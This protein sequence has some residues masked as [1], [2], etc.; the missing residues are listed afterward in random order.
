[1]LRLGTTGLMLLW[2]LKKSPPEGFNNERVAP[3]LLCGM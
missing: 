3:V 2:P 1:M